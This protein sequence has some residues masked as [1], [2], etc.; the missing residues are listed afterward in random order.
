MRSRR[1]AAM[2]TCS[3]AP[4]HQ[5]GC[6]ACLLCKATA[7]VTAKTEP[8]D[9]TGLKGDKHPPAPGPLTLVSKQGLVAHQGYSLPVPPRGDP[10]L[11]HSAFL[12][13]VCTSKEQDWRDGSKAKT[14]A[15]GEA[16]SSEPRSQESLSSRLPWVTHRTLRV[17]QLAPRAGAIAA[18][19]VQMLPKNGPDGAGPGP[20]PGRLRSQ[21]PRLWNHVF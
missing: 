21:S 8:S 5:L 16:D 15:G 10:S 9:L 14:G 20:Q 1:W 4:D 7:R 19:A 18:T 2:S 12:S 17:H 11:W 13:P 3:W 6:R